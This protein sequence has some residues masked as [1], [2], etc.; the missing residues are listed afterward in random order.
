MVSIVIFLPNNLDC[1]ELLLVEMIVKEHELVLNEALIPFKPD[2]LALNSFFQSSMLQDPTQE[3][4][5][6]TAF[7]QLFNILD[8][9]LCSLLSLDD[10][11]TQMP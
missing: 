4:H 3:L 2:D 8:A 7:F 5:D 1:L 11:L 9:Y 10:F 6:N